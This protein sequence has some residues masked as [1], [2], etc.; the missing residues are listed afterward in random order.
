MLVPELLGYLEIED[1]GSESD[2]VLN[3]ELHLI[4]FSLVEGFKWRGY[5]PTFN[6]IIPYAGMICT[7]LQD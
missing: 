5:S 3:I 6:N 2:V 7:C 1:V 4:S